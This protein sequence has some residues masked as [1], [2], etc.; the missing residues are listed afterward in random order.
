MPLRTSSSRR[1]AKNTQQH[2]RNIS[3]RKDRTKLTWRTNIS[4]CH[5]Q[6][7]TLMMRLPN[8]WKYLHSSTCLRRYRDR[9]RKMRMRKAI[10]LNQKWFYALGSDSDLSTFKITREKKI[11]RKK[12]AE[13]GRSFV[14]SRRIL[15]WYLGKNSHTNLW[16]KY[17]CECTTSRNCKPKLIR[18]RSTKNSSQACTQ[19]SSSSRWKNKS[20]PTRT[21]MP[22]LRKEK[23]QLTKLL[24]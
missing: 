3:S 5:L 9:K 22:S 16:A 14:P 20:R 4:K 1:S 6:R 10:H 18:G 8:W 19:K 15:K 2:I 12:K 11:T 23:T 7:R 21:L 13:E 17:I 24:R